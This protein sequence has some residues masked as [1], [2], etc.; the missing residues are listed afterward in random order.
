MAGIGTPSFWQRDAAELLPRWPTLE[1]APRA[2][3]DVLIVGAGLAGCSAARELISQG[4]SAL[5]VDAVGP[6]AGAS[7]RNAGFVMLGNAIDYPEHVRERGRERA[8]LLLELGRRNHRE[9]REPYGERCEHRACGSLMLAELDDPRAQATLDEAAALLAEDGVALELGPPPAG[10][11]GFG[12]ALTVYEDATVH[13]GKLLA[14]LAEGLEGRRGMIH[15]IDDRR[16]I[17]RVDEHELQFER[18]LICANAFSRALVPELESWLTPQRAQVLLTEPIA[19]LLDR[20]CYAGWGYDYFRQLA[21]GSL[22]LGGRRH[23]FLADE[24]SGEAEPSEA[25]QRSLDDYRAQHMPSSRDARVR[26]RWAGIM[27][28]SRDGLPLLGS[29]PGRERIDVLAGFTGHGLGMAV[30]CGKLAARRM[31]DRLATDDLALVELFDAGRMS[32]IR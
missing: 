28:F 4:R 9:I 5:I 21:D 23:L 27:G 15:A 24:Q 18:V 22:L 32:A 12:R 30:A 29:L 20:P 16:G 3:V 8:R 17:A 14:A 31:V 6:G 19:P 11:V 7:G 25:V 13:P 26:H 1:Q 2:R 10:L